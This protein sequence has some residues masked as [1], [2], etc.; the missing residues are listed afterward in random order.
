MKRFLF[1]I[2]AFIYIVA[3]TGA[4]MHLHYCMGRL[5]DTGFFEQEGGHCSLCGMEKSNDGDENGC[6]TDKEET[7][8]ISIDQKF[9]A[10]SVFHF[11]QPFTDIVA[12]FT[13]FQPSLDV[14][15]DDKV[16]PVS[17]APPRSPQVPPYLMHCHF[18]I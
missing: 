18:S 7:V 8:K 9:A 5:A 14:R 3:S 2:L 15:T 11:V 4:T 16:P 17:N 1:S 10:A 6:C 13:G 12:V